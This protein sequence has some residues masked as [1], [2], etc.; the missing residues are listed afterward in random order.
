L[1]QE[2]GKSLSNKSWKMS[3]QQNVSSCQNGIDVK[4]VSAL[5]HLFVALA[6]QR[7]ILK[8]R[9]VVLSALLLQS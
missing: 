3:T 6:L 8:W 7:T 9:R 5:A 1:K 4:S 2:A